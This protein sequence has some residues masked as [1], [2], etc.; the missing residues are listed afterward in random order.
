M[1]LALL[2][3]I[4]G[5]TAATAFIIGIVIDARHPSRATTGWALARG[6]P[7]DPAAMGLE[8]SAEL[9][10]RQQSAW[11][12]R[13]KACESGIV[14]IIVHGWRRSRIDSLRRIRPWLD[15]SESVWLIDLAGHGDSP[16]GPS[17]L[18]TSDVADLVALA[19][20]ILAQGAQSAGTPSRILLVGHS[21]GASIALRAA[22]RITPASLGGVVAFAPYESLAEP[23]RNRLAA[24]ALPAQP[25][26]SIAAAGL[27]AIC[28]SESSTTEAMTTLTAAGVPL[29]VVAARQDGVVSLAHV[30][31]MCMRAGVEITVDDTAQHD[32]L[33]T[34]LTA[35]D[36]NPTAVAAAA[37][38]QR[39]NNPLLR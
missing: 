31:A 36:D 18:G 6:I 35:N 8:A 19:N 33:G 37:F 39:V 25:F 29:L 20:E 17:S 30:R 21:L 22:A 15:A 38:L 12:V 9:W 1:G 3:L 23:L 34:G 14:T 16:A 11:R 5:I 26:A 24:R 2:F 13:G 7:I 32:D 28:G 10:G 4:G 27:H